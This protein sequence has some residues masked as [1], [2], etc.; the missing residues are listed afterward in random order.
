VATAVEESIAINARL[1]AVEEIRV[2]IIRPEEAHGL[3]SSTHA[4]DVMDFKKGP[5]QQYYRDVL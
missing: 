4:E 2:V 5:N 1:A 3:L